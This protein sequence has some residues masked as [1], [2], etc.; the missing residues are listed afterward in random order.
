[1]NNLISTCYVLEH[2]YGIEPVIYLYL[3]VPLNANNYIHKFDDPFT[4][5][6]F[7]R[8]HRGLDSKVTIAKSKSEN[9]NVVNG[10]FMKYVFSKSPVSH[11]YTYRILWSK[12]TYVY[13]ADDLVIASGSQFNEVIEMFD[14]LGWEMI[15]EP[16]HF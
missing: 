15:C 7:I 12:D 13:K 1:M 10:W 8:Y 16:L 6:S 2:G 5:R 11:Y 4:A 3:P 14:D 9:T